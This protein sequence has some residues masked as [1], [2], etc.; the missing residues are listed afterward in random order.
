MT[1][2]IAILST[3]LSFASLSSSAQ[4]T[5]EDSITWGIVSDQQIEQIEA[6]A[7]NGHSTSQYY[8]GRCYFNGLGVQKD[9]DKAY[10]YYAMAAEKDQS[11]ALYYLGFCS[12]YGYGT[13]K[14]ESKAE[15]FF[16]RAV[17]WLSQETDTD[18][19]ADY[20]LAM[21]HA[22]GFGVDVDVEK[23]NQLY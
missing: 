2:K 7:A 19:Y 20:Y 6:M 3:I 5:L 8:L 9:R 4:A 23:S 21:C 16:G 10:E 18:S 13:A 12:K 15:Q 17:K 11:M 1:M 14:N 22:F